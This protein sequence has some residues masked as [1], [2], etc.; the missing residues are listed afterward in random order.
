MRKINYALRITHYER[1][2]MNIK[3]KTTARTANSEEI[4]IFDADTRDE[5]G[6]AVNIGKL[7][8]HFVDDQ[9]VGTLLIW[10]E[11]AT[12]FNRTHGP[13]S[14]VTMDTLID[15]ILTQ[16][17]E[18]LGVPGDYGIEVYYPS[19]TN[20]QF[21]SNYADEDAETEGEDEEYSEDYDEEEEEPKDEDE[22]ARQLQSRP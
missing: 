2:T 1:S 21:V 16:I 3:L 9:V 19:I 13:G 5:S 15:E 8:A 20:H 12:G 4:A 17:S 6:N 18:P 11:Y 14:D 22:F 7:D 10:Q